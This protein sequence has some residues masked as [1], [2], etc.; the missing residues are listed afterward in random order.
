MHRAIRASRTR[1][2]GQ[3]TSLSSDKAPEGYISLE[4]HQAAV[5]T[6]YNSGVLDGNRRTMAKVRELLRDAEALTLNDKEEVLTQPIEALRLTIRAFNILRREGVIT[7]QDLTR[8]AEVEVA[9]YRNMG[10]KTLDEIK[11]KL[12]TYGLTLDTFR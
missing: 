4:D 12:A 8:K 1:E 2:I 9:E 3:V 11:E 6:A 7:V 10:K 5:N